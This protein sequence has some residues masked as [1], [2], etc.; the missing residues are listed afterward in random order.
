MGSTVGQFCIAVADLERSV[1][2][3]TEILG[4]AE[5][6]RTGIPHVNEVV[7]AGAEGGGRIQLAKFAETLKP[8]PIDHGNALW[9][10]YVNVDDC[11]IAW[12]RA[13]DAG[14]ESV[15]APERLDRWPVVVAFVYDPDGYL[16][17]I[18]QHDGTRPGH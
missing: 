5:Q 18:I 16:V 9:K 1:H 8:M 11:A 17:E 13:V 12:Q 15:M 14:Y 10:I 6:S 3:Y 7:V 2:F 4:L